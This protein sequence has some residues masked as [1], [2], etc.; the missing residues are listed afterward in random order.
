M[1]VRRFAA[2]QRFGMDLIFVNSGKRPAV[3]TSALTRFGA[4]T[5]FPSD[6]CAATSSP[7]VGFTSIVPNGTSRGSGTVSVSFSGPAFAGINPSVTYGPSSTPSSIAANIAALI[8][9]N[10]YRYGLGA[11]AFGSTIVYSGNASL[12]AVSN[13]VSGS[14]FSTDS[15]AGAGN[16]A[17]ISCRNAPP[18]PKSMYAVAYAAYIPVDHV[19]GPDQ[20]TYYPPPYGTSSVT[21]QLL[22]RG[23]G[24][25]NS[26]RVT[27]AVSLNF[28]ESQA[29]GYFDDTGTTEN[30]GFG[31]PYN[32]ANA[33]LSYYD[34]DS[35]YEDDRGPNPTGTAD[36][37]LR[38]AI[39]KAQPTGWTLNATVY[40]S[41]ASVTMSGK[42][43]NPLSYK[44]GNIQWSM[45]TNIDVGSN[46]GSVTYTH[47]CY[48]AH[49]VR[50]ANTTLYSYPG[51][52]D[53]AFSNSSTYIVKC[54]TGVN[55]EVRDTSPTK[56]IR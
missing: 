53:T 48:P 15:S 14:S 30:Y 24:F 51:P 23:D 33:T 4:Y 56:T 2:N 11:R 16:A 8:T 37:F 45:I 29:S 34:D 7:Q 21:A 12:G 32:G 40:P 43:Q 50:V 54:L 46:T 44:I 19:A 47:T 49:Q 5:A 17:E 41:R 6:P 10:Y 55:D 28:N 35:V 20:C 36:C 22:Y 31:S 3:V 1:N 25:H 9:K 27:Q 13:V 42:S 18:P 39:G 26:Y 52:S 38:N